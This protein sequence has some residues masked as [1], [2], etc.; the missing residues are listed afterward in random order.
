MTGKTF[1]EIK[2]GLEDAIEYA[3]GDA[4]RGDAHHVEVPTV[5]VRAVRERLEMSQE[6]FA[7]TFMVSVGTVRNWEQGRRIPE[8]PARVL[9]NVIQREPKAVLRA[10]RRM[11]KAEQDDSA[12]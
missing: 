9:L 5:D 11:Q 12:A 7:E 1:E 6:R 8:G 3:K 10:L 2:A 4:T